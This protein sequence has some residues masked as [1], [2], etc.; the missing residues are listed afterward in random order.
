MSSSS[1]PVPVG[2]LLRRAAGFMPS[3]VSLVSHG[4]VVMTVSTLQCLSCDPPIVSV[5]FD[6]AS[7]KGRA[8]LEA[9]RFEARVLRASEAAFAREGTSRPVDAALVALDCEILRAEPVGDHDLVLAGVTRVQVGDGG[10]LVYWRR[11]L[12]PLRVDYPFLATPSTLAAFIAAWE[13]GTLPRADWTHAAHVA[14]A[15]CYAVR[16]GAAALDRTR[17]GIVRYNLAVGTPNTET[18]GFHETLTRFWAEVVARVTAGCDDDWEA[19]RLAVG[20]VGEDRDLHTLCYAFDVPRSTV[21]RRAWVA[22]DWP[23]ADVLA[24]TSTGPVPQG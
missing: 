18:S 13:A 8:I 5:C 19:A 12:H 1:A 10:P 9:A 7:R 6:R 21:A 15:A 22:P 3:A 20:R 11:G 24:L 23:I 14:V 2:R 17:A 16:H 4:D